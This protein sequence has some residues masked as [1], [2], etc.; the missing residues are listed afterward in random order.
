MV[1]V[2]LETN[3]GCNL[4][5][6]Q[7][8]DQELLGQDTEGAS[9]GLGKTRQTSDVIFLRNNHLNRISCVK[10]LRDKSKISSF[11]KS[12]DISNQTKTNSKTTFD[13]QLVP[14]LFSGHSRQSKVPYWLHFLSCGLGGNPSAINQWSSPG[15]HSHRCLV[16]LGSVVRIQTRS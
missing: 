9:C 15:V 11:C 13:M 4:F 1:C 14:L 10:T 8:S 16:L 5:E 3:L 12:T 2:S 6:E 7:I